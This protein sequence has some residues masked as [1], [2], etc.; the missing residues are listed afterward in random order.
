M[1]LVNLN[2]KLNSFGKVKDGTRKVGRGNFPWKKL[3]III[4][5]L[6]VVFYLPA[7]G[8]YS[9]A[10]DISKNGKQ[11]S[12]GFKQNDLELIKKGVVDTKSSVE[13]LD[14]SLNWF[15]W[16]KII[17]FLGGFYGDAKSFASAA[18]EEMKAAE[19]IV[20]SLDPY[21]QELNLNGQP[22]AGQ[23][24]LA[25]GIKIL[26]KVLP[27]MDKVVPILKK[28]G[29]EVKGIDA[30]KYP[31]KFGNIRVRDRVEQLKDFIIG[32]AVAVDKHR[33]ALEMA[34]DALGQVSPKT[35]L[36]LF[37]NDKELRPTGGFITAYTFLK[38]DKGYISTTVS[39]D[40]YRLDEKLLVTCESKICPLTPPA[41]I[42]KYLPEVSGKPRSAWSMRDS[43]ISPDLPTAAFEFER[44]YS[45]LG[46]GLPFDGII[47]ID[48]QVVEE[49]I[50][51]TGP[52]EVYGTT[53]S[54]EKDPRCNCPNVIYELEHYAEVAA[55][56]EKDRKAVLGTLMQQIL[57]RALGSGVDKVPDFLTSGVRLANDKHIMFFMHNLRIQQALSKL[58][59]TGQIQAFDGDYLHI[60]DSNFAGGK[61]NLYVEEKV[62]LDIKVD[63][64]GNVTNKVIIDYK[65]PQPFN[66]WL[67][68]IL[69][70]YVR[71]YVPRGSKLISSKGS[72]DPVNTLNDEGLSKTYFDAFVQV[73]PQ[74]S[75][76][77][78]FEYTLPNKI[79]GKTLPLLIQKQPG[80]KDHHYIVKVNGSTKAEFDLTSD[81]QL[82][83]SF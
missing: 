65:N 28:A 15:I 4:F 54:A 12:A 52:V 72:D 79:T 18:S 10:K 53:Y 80:A 20:N 21:K 60:N 14:G 22:V 69:R 66:T 6:L 71:I 58:N 61:S 3:F 26:D 33:D 73:R 19:I 34:P 30:G 45:L 43:N 70:D 24:Q 67:N 2:R 31:E 23:D 64:S 38:L 49:L 76:T 37:Q 63:S 39:D 44:M 16:L 77:L 82:N 56:G 35:Y 74:N 46:D 57:G 9:A 40:I 81:K 48:T 50:S 11:I 62:T 75:R 36:V 5:V 47:T 29:E 13:A 41:P 42:V 32:A 83:L 8:V 51:I 17:P 27:N 1:P 7:R 78:S 59:W 68:G 55:K 25:Q